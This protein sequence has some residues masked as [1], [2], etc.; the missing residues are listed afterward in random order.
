[1]NLLLDVNTHYYF[2]FY[3]GAVLKQTLLI[4]YISTIGAIQIVLVLRYRSYQPD[5]TTISLDYL[6]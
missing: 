3:A 1:M 5:L 6:G 2:Q 4:E